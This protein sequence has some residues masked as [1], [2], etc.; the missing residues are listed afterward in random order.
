MK[1]KLKFFATFPTSRDDKTYCK[2]RFSLPTTE[3]IE[4]IVFFKMDLS[5]LSVTEYNSF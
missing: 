2:M 3:W 5:T 1:L 4:Q